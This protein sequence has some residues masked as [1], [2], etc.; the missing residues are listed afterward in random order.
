MTRISKVE[1]FLDSLPPENE[2][3]NNWLIDREAELRMNG[4]GKREAKEKAL[5]DW[6]IYQSQHQKE[7]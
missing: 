7:S 6:A 2:A 4:Y 3:K 5:Y 1:K